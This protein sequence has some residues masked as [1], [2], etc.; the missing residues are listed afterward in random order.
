MGV[1]HSVTS[2]QFTSAKL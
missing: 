2:V 1:E